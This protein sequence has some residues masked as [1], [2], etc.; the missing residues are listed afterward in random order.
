VVTASIGIAR[1]QHSTA[2]EL[3][4]DSDFA[5]YD[6]KGSGRNRWAIFESGAQTAA[7]DRLALAMD[8][9]EALDGDQL[10]LL[11]QPTVDLQRETIT[12]ME[13]LIR[14]R[15]PARGV[16]APGA[17]IPL[18]EETGLIAPIGQWVLRSACAQTV[19]WNR[20]GLD[21]GVSVNVSPSQVDCEG[22]VDEVAEIVAETGIDPARLTL[23]ITETTLM[24]DPVAAGR[25]LR[26]LKALGVVIAI[27]DFGTGYS[28]LAY[29]CQFPVDVLKI[30]RSFVAGIADST[31]AKAVIHTLIQL[32]K[33]LGLQTLAEGIEDRSQLRHLQDESCDC[34]QGFLFARPLGVR[35]VQ[36]LLA[37]TA[38]QMAVAS[39]AA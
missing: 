9:G 33:T 29:L 8:L 30:D 3:L 1:G 4:R 7:Q 32:G 34:G 23:E 27:D 12:G 2:D 19:A 20:D 31:E 21:L 22:F 39:A 6:A 24:R 25:R 11:Y 26:E 5:L 36:E 38:S 28:S 10:F 35:A 37:P 17:F 13:A 18:A 14:W 16:L 15:H